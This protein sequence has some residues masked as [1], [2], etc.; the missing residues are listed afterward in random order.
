MKNIGNYEKKGIIRIN[1]SIT[2]Y[3]RKALFAQHGMVTGRRENTP[4]LR[5]QETYPLLAR[6]KVH[7]RA[8][9]NAPTSYR[10][11]CLVKSVI[12]SFSKKKFSYRIKSSFIA[13]PV[14]SPTNF[15]QRTSV[16]KTLAARGPTRQNSISC[17]TF[18]RLPSKIASTLPSDM[19]L[20]HPFTFS[21][22]AS[23][24]VEALKNTPWTLPVTK[25]WA[26][27]FKMF[28]NL[29]W[30]TKKTSVCKQRLCLMFMSFF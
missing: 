18:S 26:R 3:L 16:R 6:S 10:F 19:F 9:T 13:K 28:I 24:R 25:M 7:T 1:F 21:L 17:S 8:C 20:I 22:I 14:N 2:L 4:I 27:M 11:N 29:S 12:Y 15:P 30:I 23:E 5:R